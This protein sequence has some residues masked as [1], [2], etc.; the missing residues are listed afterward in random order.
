MFR[1]QSLMKVLWS[2]AILL[3]LS[4]D[5]LVALLRIDPF[6]ISCYVCVS[7]FFLCLVLCNLYCIYFSDSCVVL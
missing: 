5:C 6:L 2:G 1:M 4:L 3:G 7:V